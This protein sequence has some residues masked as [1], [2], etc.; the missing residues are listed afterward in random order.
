VDTLR[1]LLAL[2]V[3]AATEQDWSQVSVLIDKVPAVTGDT[4]AVAFVD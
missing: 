1:H 3:T 4:V 2:Y